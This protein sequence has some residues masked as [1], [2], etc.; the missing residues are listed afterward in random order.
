MV[1]LFLLP[2]WLMYSANYICQ[3]CN[4]NQ[5]FT[6]ESEQRQFKK[7]KT[8][9]NLCATGVGGKDRWRRLWIVAKCYIH[10]FCKYIYILYYIIFCIW[11]NI[12]C[13]CPPFLG[14]LSLCW[15]QSF[16]FSFL[17]H[18]FHAL[19]FNTKVN[20][21]YASVCDGNRFRF[22]VIIS[23]F[24][25]KVGQFMI[26]SV[27]L[28]FSLFRLCRYDTITNQW[29]TVSPLPK[30]VHSA[31]AT[32]CGGK[33]YVFGGVNEA[34]RSAG[35]LQSYLPQS[36]TW[37]F[38]E[39]PMIGETNHLWP[40]LRR[41]KCRGELSHVI[42]GIGLTRLLRHTSLAWQVLTG[43]GVQKMSQSK[44]VSLYSSSGWR[45]QQ[46]AFVLN[47]KELVSMETTR[48]F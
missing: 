7:K 5:R 4:H 23:I 29:E 21:W 15:T 41:L 42:V 32:V 31:A 19:Y 44:L 26:D 34:G 1:G 25:P 12:H 18:F 38:I 45:D 46:G 9:N 33:V 20:P 36:N 24:W 39:S 16:L 10:I 2:W 48:T 17:K 28:V 13:F 3:P 43:F 47:M 37:T 8:P 30:P 11:W 40:V 22:C 27:T 6:E 14:P 35:V